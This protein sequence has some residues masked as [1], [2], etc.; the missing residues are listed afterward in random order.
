MHRRPRRRPTHAPRA[1]DDHVDV[2][3]STYIIIVKIV[4]FVIE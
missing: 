1:A 4:I 3:A 2:K